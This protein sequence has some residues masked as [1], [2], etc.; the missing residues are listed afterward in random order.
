MSR[1]NST[2]R[3]AGGGSSDDFVET[4]A[5]AEITA[6]AAMARLRRRTNLGIIVDL[7]RG[8]ESPRDGAA[9]AQ[10]LV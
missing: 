3:A 2:G 8:G 6:S 7:A 4:C 5:V 10:A 9:D 1:S